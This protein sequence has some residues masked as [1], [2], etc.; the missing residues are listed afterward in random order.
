MAQ[1]STPPGFLKAMV[2]SVARHAATGL[3]GSLVALGVFSNTQSAEFT[4][5]VGALA[6]YGLTLWWSAIQ[7]KAALSPQSKPA[8]DPPS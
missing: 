6:V 8:D 1:L 5:I 2:G 4:D 3:A 7:K